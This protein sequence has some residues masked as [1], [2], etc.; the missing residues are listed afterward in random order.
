[1]KGKGELVHCGLVHC[2]LVIIRVLVL[3]AFS[4]KRL[5]QMLNMNCLSVNGRYGQV[6]ILHALVKFLKWPNLRARL[7]GRNVKFLRKYEFPKTETNLSE[8]R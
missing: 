7:R 8:Q 2:A 5:T 6:V 4:N 3:Q 1:M